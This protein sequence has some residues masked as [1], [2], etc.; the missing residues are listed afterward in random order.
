M[1]TAVDSQ[2]QVKF[3]KGLVRD[4]LREKGQVYLGCSS[5]RGHFSFW[6]TP[7]KLP[8]HISVP[9]VPVDFGNASGGESGL[10]FKKDKDR[11]NTEV[12]LHN[13]KGK[14]KE[15]YILDFFFFILDFLAEYVC[16]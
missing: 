16:T 12:S 5:W 3:E 15:E 9:F 14:Y 6:M 7:L 8:P 2:W 13:L 4:Y 1:T 10:I 11:I